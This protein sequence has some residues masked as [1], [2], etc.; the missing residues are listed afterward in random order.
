MYNFKK[1]FN[2]LIFVNVVQRFL[3]KMF[4]F[5]VQIKRAPV[6]L[7]FISHWNVCRHLKL[8]F[9]MFKL[10]KNIF[11]CFLWYLNMF[12]YWKLYSEWIFKNEHYLP[13]LLSNWVVNR[14]DNCGKR[15]FLVSL[16]FI[17]CNFLERKDIF[18]HLKNSK[19]V[20]F[21]LTSKV[22]KTNLHLYLI[23]GHLGITKLNNNWRFIFRVIKH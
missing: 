16:Y 3:K 23:M 8:D 14:N 20:C 12:V 5:A 15:T 9:T 4:A 6:T 7:N 13:I 11:K 18:N 1:H 21:A 22:P 2:Y 17:W 19:Y 10:K